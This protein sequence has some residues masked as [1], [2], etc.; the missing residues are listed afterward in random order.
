MYVNRYHLARPAP[1]QVIPVGK[2]GVLTIKPGCV[3][4]SVET[5]VAVSQVNSRTISVRYRERQGFNFSLAALEFNLKF[6]LVDP[7]FANGGKGDLNVLGDAIYLAL[8]EI[9][10]TR[11][12]P[13]IEWPFLLAVTFLQE[14]LHKI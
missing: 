4:N 12:W 13:L 3:T 5:L 11:K 6:F 2:L 14:A 10:L 9:E 7:D 8:I 1:D